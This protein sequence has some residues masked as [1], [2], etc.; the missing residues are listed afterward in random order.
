MSKWIYR[1]FAGEWMTRCPYCHW[2]TRGRV[3]LCGRCKGIFSEE[4]YAKL[5]QLSKALPIK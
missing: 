4:L 5:R 1:Q 3:Q 2:Q